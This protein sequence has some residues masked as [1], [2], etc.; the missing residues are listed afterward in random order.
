MATTGFEDFGKGGS[1]PMTLPGK[2]VLG[3][4]KSEQTI[5]FEAR[6]VGLHEA[7]SVRCRIISPPSL[8]SHTIP[9]PAN[10]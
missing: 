8:R 9:D 4:Y 6:K 1:E 3:V 5:L 10:G 2:N 7:L